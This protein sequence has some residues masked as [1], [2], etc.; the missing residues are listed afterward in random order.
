MK[1]DIIIVQKQIKERGRL[2][3]TKKEYFEELLVIPEVAENEELVAFIEKEIALLEKRSNSPK[4][5]T[6]KQLENEKL[7]EAILNE[8]EEGKEYTN[9]SMIENLKACENMSSQKLNALLVKMQNSEKVTRVVKKR[10]AYFVKGQV[11]EN[12]EE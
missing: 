11:E 9:K 6:K 8:M 12:A 1:H 3:M 10:V 5:P 4:K 2:I 7:I